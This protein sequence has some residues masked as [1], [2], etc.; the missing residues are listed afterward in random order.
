MTK[1]RFSVRALATMGL[2]AGAIACGKDEPP[3]DTAATRAA[4]EKEAI[5]ALRKPGSA[6][7][8]VPSTA[9]GIA[10]WTIHLG[11]AVTVA[12]KND[13]G[14]LRVMIAY[15]ESTSKKVAAAACAIERAGAKSASCREAAD[16]IARDLRGTVPA[17]AAPVKTQNLPAAGA[18]CAELISEQAALLPF[19]VEGAACM[20][21]NV[22]LP[23][24]P[25]MQ[26]PC[27]LTDNM[28]GEATLPNLAATCCEGNLGDMEIQ[29]PGRLINTTPVPL[30]CVNSE[31]GGAED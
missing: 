12:G 31:S 17:T 9:P 30:V 27:V 7:R 14:E 26:D 22:Q 29:D 8:T 24:G 1:A 16:A 25:A 19:I 20:E 13:K 2:L 6:M 15:K 23:D 4:L 18:G 3:P 28:G 5:A 11:A 21:G 10:T